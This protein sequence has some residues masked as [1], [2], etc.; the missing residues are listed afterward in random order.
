MPVVAGAAHPSPTGLAESVLSMPVANVY[1]V[2]SWP[3]KP[4]RPTP[5]RFRPARTLS[6]HSSLL[7]AVTVYLLL[8]MYVAHVRTL[9][10]LMGL[11]MPDEC[12]CILLR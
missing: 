10:L 7:L 5:R 1:R 2:P 6:V 9:W 12:G 4:R 8:A 3:A 11:R